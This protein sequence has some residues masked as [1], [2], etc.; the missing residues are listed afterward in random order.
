MLTVTGTQHINIHKTII[1]LKHQNPSADN[2]SVKLHHVSRGKIGASTAT[3]FFEIITNQDEQ[4]EL[5]IL[6]YGQHTTVGKGSKPRYT[7][8]TSL[9]PKHLPPGEYEVP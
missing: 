4:L 9:D 5:R 3:L 2:S 8:S 6:A 1:T 7:I